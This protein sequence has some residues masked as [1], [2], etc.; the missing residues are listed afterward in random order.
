M[1][2]D[3]AAKGSPFG[4]RSHPESSRARSSKW[5][6]HGGVWGG[7]SV[8]EDAMPHRL[9]VLEQKTPTVKEIVAGLA[10]AEAD[11]IQKLKE[12]ARK[13]K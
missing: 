2:L 8:P 7:T 5:R 6:Y 9:K 12:Q 10:K 1:G 13:K 11:E 4:R 3:R